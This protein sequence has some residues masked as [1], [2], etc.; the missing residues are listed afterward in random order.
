VKTKILIGGSDVATKTLKGGVLIVTEP[1]YNE[2]AVIPE[3]GYKPMYG[4]NG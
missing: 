2:S 4:P 1:D 3:S